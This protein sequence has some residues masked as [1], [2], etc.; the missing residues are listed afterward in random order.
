MAVELNAPLSDEL[1]R[2]SARAEAAGGKV[3]VEADDGR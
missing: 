1:F 2:A 3:T